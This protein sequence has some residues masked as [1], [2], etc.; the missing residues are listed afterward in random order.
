MPNCNFFQFVRA[1]NNPIATNIV[2]KERLQLESTGANFG[3][4]DEESA[5]QLAGFT[6]A[7]PGQFDP[8][9]FVGEKYKHIAIA[10]V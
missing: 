4:T 8:I 6:I 3:V 5:G 7:A 1:P 10:R 9:L 2:K